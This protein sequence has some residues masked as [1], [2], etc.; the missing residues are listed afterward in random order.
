MTINERIKLIRQN[1]GLNQKLFSNELGISQGGVSWMEKPGNNISDQSKKMICA[2]FHIHEEWLETGNGD[3]YVQSEKDIVE[4]LVKQYHMS[5]EQKKLMEI[6]LS[7][8]EEKRDA[9]SKA[10]FD[11]IEA[12]INIKSKHTIKN[13]GVRRKMSTEMKRAIVNA[14]LLDEQKVKMS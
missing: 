9:V 7:M 1:S 12:A 10:F 4:L 2:K 14:E 5:L 13:K 6:F 8:S 11:V 3:M